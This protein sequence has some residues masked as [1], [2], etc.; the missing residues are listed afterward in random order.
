MN[1]SDNLKIYFLVDTGNVW[2]NEVGDCRMHC[3][4]GVMETEKYEDHNLTAQ[5]L[6]L[7]TLLDIKQG[8][9]VPNILENLLVS[10]LILAKPSA[11]SVE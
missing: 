10:L 4:E 6:Y 5:Y 8:K 1:S 9:P 3:A 7:A 11:R 2:I